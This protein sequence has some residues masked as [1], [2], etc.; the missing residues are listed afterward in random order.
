MTENLAEYFDEDTS[1][2]TNSREIIEYC[3]KEGK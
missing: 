3:K 2:V 1:G